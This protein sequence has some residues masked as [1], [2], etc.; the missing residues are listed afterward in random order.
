MVGAKETDVEAA[1]GARVGHIVLLDPTTAIMVRRGD[2]G[3]VPNLAV[4]AA[5]LHRALD[6]R[7]FAEQ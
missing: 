1:R 5:L 3:R 2:H 7:D 6:T 4:V